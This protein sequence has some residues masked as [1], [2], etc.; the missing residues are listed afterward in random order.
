MEAMSKD[1][2]LKEKKRQLARRFV[3]RYLYGGSNKCFG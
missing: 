2:S 3:K 1:A